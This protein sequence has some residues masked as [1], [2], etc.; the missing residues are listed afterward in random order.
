MTGPSLEMK[1]LVEKMG[2][3]RLGMCCAWVGVGVSS[4]LQKFCY[5]DALTFEFFNFL[6]RNLKALPGGRFG[7]GEEGHSTE[8]SHVC[9]KL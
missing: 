3:P 1:D 7:N 2:G 4:H 8:A 5:C 6:I 9:I